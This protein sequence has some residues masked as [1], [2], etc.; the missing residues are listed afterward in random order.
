MELFITQ[1]QILCICLIMGLCT[2]QSM[3]TRNWKFCKKRLLQKNDNNTIG[4]GYVG[5]TAVLKFP[6]EKSQEKA[7]AASKGLILL[8]GMWSEV[9]D[10]E[11]DLLWVGCLESTLQCL[12]TTTRI[13]APHL[14]GL[15]LS[16]KYDILKNPWVSII[17]PK[18]WK[19]QKL[20][21]IATVLPRC[22]LSAWYS[23][24]SSSKLGFSRFS[25]VKQQA[26]VVIGPAYYSISKW[27]N[28]R[29]LILD[30]VQLTRIQ[31]S[32]WVSYASNNNCHI[33]IL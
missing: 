28:L 14:V 5:C 8:V 17:T 24:Q 3:Y 4:I 13:W 30:W 10:D 27:L 7:A 20:Q 9:T 18:T 33:F 1:S 15:L 29:T 19:M 16:I 2:M 12:K 32:P 11:R 26:K 21:I 22:N 6:H 23:G 25:K 31:D